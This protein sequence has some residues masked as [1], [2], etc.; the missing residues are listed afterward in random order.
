MTICLMNNN[1][2]HLRQC[3]ETI[4]KYKRRKCSNSRK[5]DIRDNFLK[6]RVFTLRNKHKDSNNCLNIK[7]NLKKRSTCEVYSMKISMNRR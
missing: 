3:K 1:E 6:W 4:I 2:D 7:N 5:R